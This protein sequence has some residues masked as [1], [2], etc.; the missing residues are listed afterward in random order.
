MKKIGGSE[1]MM[2]YWCP[3]LLIDINRSWSRSRSRFILEGWEPEPPKIGRLRNSAV[4]VFIFW[5]TFS[6]IFPSFFFSF[7][8]V[9]PFTH[10]TYFATTKNAKQEKVVLFQ[11]WNMTIDNKH[12]TVAD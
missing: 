8:F 2:S 7:S 11:N 12:A 1:I 5:V 4:Y 10:Y 3:F 9:A 6:T